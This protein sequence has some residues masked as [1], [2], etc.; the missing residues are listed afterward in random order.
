MKPRDRTPEEQAAVDE[1]IR[2]FASPIVGQTIVELR[3]MTEDEKVDYG[4]DYM[5]G[6]MWAIVLS[7]GT[8]LF[9]SRDEEGNGPGDL[10]VLTPEA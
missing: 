4:W 6:V 9:P 10:F 5:H 1:W 2:E 7:N 8:R 3:E